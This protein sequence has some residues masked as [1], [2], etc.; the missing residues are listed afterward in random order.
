MRE[1]TD[2]GKPA[3]TEHLLHCCDQI[4]GQEQLRE[5]KACFS[6]GFGTPWQQKLEVVGDMA[7][8]DGEQGGD[9]CWAGVLLFIPFT[10]PAQ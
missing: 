4:P 7:S 2:E 3:F 8:T 6:S 1:G 5:G 10:V 9:H